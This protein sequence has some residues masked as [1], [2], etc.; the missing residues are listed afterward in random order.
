MRRRDTRLHTEGFEGTI[1]DTRFLGFAS[2]GHEDH[3]FA[4]G[5]IFLN[6]IRHA[7]ESTRRNHRTHLL[8]PERSA[9]RTP[10]P[11]RAE[12]AETRAAL[13]RQSIPEERV[14]RALGRLDRCAR[15]HRTSSFREK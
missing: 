3:A 14:G 13:R 7:R 10:R 4:H 5:T 6:A 9:Q 12:R 2:T 1:L 15:V 11:I 8:E